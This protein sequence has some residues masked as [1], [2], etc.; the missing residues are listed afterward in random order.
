MYHC[1]THF[2]LVGCQCRESEIIRGITPLE[3]FSHEFSE[4]D[5]PEETLAAAADVIL[6]DAMSDAVADGGA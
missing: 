4:S 2:Y 1:H 3:H 5:S 6:A